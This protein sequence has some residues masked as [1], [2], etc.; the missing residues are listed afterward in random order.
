MKTKKSNSPFKAK[1]IRKVYQHLCFLA[2][3]D[4]IEKVTNPEQIQIVRDARKKMLE[5]Y[6]NVLSKTMSTPIQIDPD[7]AAEMFHV[8]TKKETSP[9]AVSNKRGS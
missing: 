2:N 7:F 3:A 6:G 5:T 1:T 8:L 9:M 4:G